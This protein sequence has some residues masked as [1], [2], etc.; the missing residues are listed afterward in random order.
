MNGMTFI[1]WAMPTERTFPSG[2][3]S[4]FAPA[5]GRLQSLA[6]ST[7]SPLH[8]RTP[9]FLLHRWRNCKG[10][11]DPQPQ[12]SPQNHLFWF[13]DQSGHCSRSSGR[14]CS[15]CW[16]CSSCCTI[17]ARC[18][19]DYAWGVKWGGEVLCCRRFLYYPCSPLWVSILDW[20]VGLESLKS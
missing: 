7:P 10:Q 1:E 5:S 17:E 13:Q 14:V 18:I 3:W 15:H 16:P 4:Y 8:A 6:T 11:Y 12:S 9:P 19:A 2:S 20:T